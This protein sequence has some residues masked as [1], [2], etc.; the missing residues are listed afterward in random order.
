MK[1]SRQMPGCAVGRLNLGSSG[2][3]CAVCSPASGNASHELVPPSYDRARLCYHKGIRIYTLTSGYL[4][5][6]E[7]FVF[8]RDRVLL[9]SVACSTGK[10]SR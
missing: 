1:S 8:H 7:L 2:V 5:D 10:I 9:L 3:V 4:A 6:V